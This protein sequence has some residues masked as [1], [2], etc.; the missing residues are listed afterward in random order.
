MD[1]Q[2]K[3]TLLGALLSFAADE[4][5]GMESRGEP[6]AAHDL[7][8][9]DSAMH[10]L[11][12]NTAML[13]HLAEGL[14]RVASS[15][16]AE[17]ARRKSRL[18]RAQTER[19]R[20]G[21]SAPPRG[22]GVPFE[23]LAAAITTYGSGGEHIK[24]LWVAG[25]SMQESAH[26]ALA[27]A[28]ESDGAMQPVLRE[29]LMLESTSESWH[30]A[31]SPTQSPGRPHSH[32][33]TTRNQSPPAATPPTPA[34]S[35]FPERRR[36]HSSF[37]AAESPQ[38][39]QPASETAGSGGQE[40]P[41][42]TMMSLLLAAESA[43]AALVGNV[44]LVRSPEARSRAAS[45]EP[46]EEG[47]TPAL[48]R[49]LSFT[50]TS[51]PLSP[52]QMGSSPPREEAAGGESSPTAAMAAAVSSG[53][54]WGVRV[55]N[56]QQITGSSDELSLLLLRTR[57]GKCRSAASDA[58]SPEPQAASPT[59]VMSPMSPDVAAELVDGN[60]T[61]EEEMRSNLLRALMAPLLE[62][63][64]GTELALRALSTVALLH[65]ELRLACAEELACTMGTL[66]LLIS[67]VLQRWHT[68]LETHLS[69]D[70]F[71]GGAVLKSLGSQLRNRSALLLSNP[72]RR[73]EWVAKRLWAGLL[74]SPAWADL[75]NGPSVAEA[76]LAMA[77]FDNAKASEFT[78]VVQMGARA[79]EVRCQEV[80]A[81]W[82]AIST[83]VQEV[84]GAWGP[85]VAETPGGRGVRK[86]ADRE[87]SRRSMA[88]AVEER[89][90]AGEEHAWRAFTRRMLEHRTLFAAV[91]TDEADVARADK[92][93]YKVDPVETGLRQHPRL[94]RFH[95]G[96][97]HN[98][99]A[100]KSQGGVEQPAEAMT[101]ITPAPTPVPIKTDDVDGLL[102]GESSEEEEAENEGLGADGTKWS[103]SRR[104]SGKAVEGDLLEPARKRS[105]SEGQGSFLDP[106]GR[107]RC[108]AAAQSPLV[109]AGR[110][111]ERAKTLVDNEE[112]IV[113]ELPASLVQPLCVLGQV[114]L[115]TRQIY[116]LI[117]APRWSPCERT[118]GVGGG[119]TGTK[120]FHWPLSSLKQV[121]IRRYLLKRSAIELFLA[122]HTNHFVNFES[123]EARQ[124]MVKAVMEQRPLNLDRFF[125]HSPKPSELLRKSGL[126]LR[127]QRREISNFEYLMH[128]NTLAGR[129]YNDI[130]QYPVFPW[131]IA[132]YTSATLDWDDPNTFRDLTKP[133]GALNPE[134]LQKFLERYD[135]FDDPVIPKF[136]YGSHYS[137]A[138]TVLYYLV[139][140][141]PYTTL[142]IALQGGKF[143]HPD[144]MF[145]DVATSWKGCLSDMSDVKEVVPE[146][147]YLPE[148]FMNSSKFDFGCKQTGE[149]MNDVVL[150]PWA[151]DAF[152]FVQKQRAALEGEY[153]SM[154]LH[155]WIDL[156]FGYKQRGQ[157]SVD[158]ANRFYYLTY[159]G[160]VDID[161]IEDPHL[162]KATQDQIAFFGQTPSQLLTAAHPQ[163]CAREE[164]LQPLFRSP[165]D[166]LRW[167]PLPSPGVLGPPPIN[168]T[169]TAEGMVAIGKGIQGPSLMG[170]FPVVSHKWQP[171]HADGRGIPFTFSPDRLAQ[172]PTTTAIWTALRRSLPRSSNDP[173]GPEEEDIPPALPRLCAVLT[174]QRSTA[175]VRQL[176]VVTPD[177]RIA[178]LG[179]QAGCSLQVYSLESGKAL[180]GVTGHSEAVTCVALDKEG[181]MLVSGGGDA[182]ITV[183]AVSSPGASGRGA[184]S[185]GSREAPGGGAGPGASGQSYITTAVK[186]VAAD[187]LSGPRPGGVGEEARGRGWGVG[188]RTRE[189]RDSGTH[190]SG[191]H[192]QGPLHV[193][194]GH[195]G[196]ISAV[197]VSSDLDMVASCS[198]GEGLLLHSLVKGRLIRRIAGVDGTLLTITAQG[199]TMSWNAA[200][201]VLRCVSVNGRLVSAYAV[202]PE[203][204]VVTGMVVDSEGSNL[205]LGTSIEGTGN[206]RGGTLT[207]Y[208]LHALAPIH[209]LPLPDAAGVAALAL[210]HDNTNMLVA[211]TTGQL[212]VYT[213]PAVS[214]KLMDKMLRIGW[215][216][217]GLA[218]LV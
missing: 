22:A 119:W 154:H 4:I 138:G 144:R 134:R 83:Q 193:L 30:P 186:Q 73:S 111:A 80:Q 59:P 61:R 43:V 157:E 64:P 205:V 140:L 211:T 197:S 76:L 132:D 150:P 53:S 215:A 210:T 161:S 87:F 44:A 63:V 39:R 51:G 102:E 176:L 28:L 141:E 90:A 139:R 86:L 42:D 145:H 167:Y 11:F 14:L 95:G 158:A 168:L 181:S 136:H 207:V 48:K 184:A 57:L 79:S 173:L 117:D 151:T 115:T 99:A 101:P 32:S 106:G 35:P 124:K 34:E 142:A 120:E 47:T 3:G 121:H 85:K 31:H 108:P 118:G 13:V 71:G 116:F 33:P 104:R 162:L 122:D 52:R 19:L 92:I 218:S 126:T 213:D 69:T 100:Q 192:L 17:D 123:K 46:A 78:L 65:V 96:L 41:V 182:T 12:S 203:D 195:R 164:A 89:E 185:P 130:T 166:S 23:D 149:R 58:G 27:G 113:M 82:E 163:R 135:A 153:V 24:R 18:V 201:R 143:D 91:L 214:V 198:Q 177:G 204:G 67:S 190:F 45:R 209:R 7:V 60:V 54:I 25:A 97:D 171:N 152:D 81:V 20:Q 165:K 188:G 6:H 179:G 55:L 70:S 180:E 74:T 200:S 189:R 191:K 217:G 1:Q 155:H 37:I 49:K 9:A 84:E 29:G 72:T 183:W 131:V 75:F 94:K 16:R 10:V 103:P 125:Y 88:R 110:A 196:A 2:V 174:G 199:H 128:L 56:L 77:S 172:M 93:F 137:S 15:M 206:L 178:I 66:V 187:Q 175:Q 38:P 21:P 50:L 202:P 26:S 147:F 169:I 170:G 109:A 40:A 208:R 114:Q 5:R 156:V 194:R 36:P 112:R 62:E 148:M 98:G 127:W 216:E 133:I 107:T 146:F 129:T 159:E 212:L 105:Q 68:H 8:E 160:M